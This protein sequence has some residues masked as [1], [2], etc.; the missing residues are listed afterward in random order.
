MGYFDLQVNGYGGV[1]FNQDDL[2]AEDLHNAC[3]KLRDDGVEGVLATIITEPLETM[4]RRI[5]RLVTLRQK[6]ALVR[7]M[8]AGIHVEGPFI[9]SRSGFV[10]AHPADAVIPATPSAAQRLVDAGEGLLQLLTLAPECDAGNRPAK[11]AASLHK[12]GARPQS[13]GVTVK[14]R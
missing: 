11:R 12:A 9:S 10:G 8:I 5:R 1:D 14:S 4:D 7:Q 2:A 3:Q 6:D 13:A